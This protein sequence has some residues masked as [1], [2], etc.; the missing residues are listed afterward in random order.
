MKY[1]TKQNTEQHKE[2]QYTNYETQLYE[3]KK[4]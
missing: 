4:S 2:T 1:N 3:D